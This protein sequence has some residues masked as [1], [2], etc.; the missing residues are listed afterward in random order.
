MVA[1]NR[2]TRDGYIELV[3]GREVVARSLDRDGIGASSGYLTVPDLI[4]GDVARAFGNGAVIATATYDGGPRI[5]TDACAGSAAFTVARRGRRAGGV[6][7]RVPPGGA[8]VPDLRLAWTDAAS[9]T[10]TAEPALA[11]GQSLRDPDQAPGRRC[12]GHLTDRRRDRRVR[13]RGADRRAGA[14]G[15]QARRR[16]DGRETGDAGPA[17]LALRTRLPFRFSEAGSVRLELRDRAGALL[18]TGAKR[19][20]AAWPMYVPADR[21]G[22]RLLARHVADVADRELRARTRGDEAGAAVRDARRPLECCA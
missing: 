19:L 1:D 2:T 17:A 14:D 8:L 9:F 5:G 6:G 4:A 16:G 12:R 7:R 20:P 21:R 15:D 22:R 13:A 3:R 11:A 10:V 18:G